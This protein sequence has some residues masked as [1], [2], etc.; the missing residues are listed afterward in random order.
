[1]AINQIACT[2]PSLGNPLMFPSRLCFP[3]LL[4][5]ALFP[6][7]SHAETLPALTGPVLLTVTG[8]DPADYAE[9][10]AEFDI[11]RLKAM[12][13]SE[14]ETSTIWTEGKHRFSGVM[15]RDMVEFLDVSEFNLR[16]HALNDYAVEFLSTEATAEAPL[17]AYEMDGVAMSVR[18]KGPLWVMFPFDAS[19]QYRTDTIYSRSIWQ[20]DRIDVLR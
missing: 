16:F 1:M 4:A 18:D 9:G 8:L 5:L 7:F 3:A 15:L 11:G 19:P 20:L 10:K 13:Q 2:L 14:F 6:G 17:L 12:A